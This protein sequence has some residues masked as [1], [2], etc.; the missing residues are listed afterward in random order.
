VAQA[1]VPAIRFSDCGAARKSSD[2]P[3]SHHPL[4]PTGNTRLADDQLARALIS[5]TVKG[6]TTF[7]FR[8]KNDELELKA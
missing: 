3:C 6:N 4:R 7:T 2:P 8:V 5:G 1:S